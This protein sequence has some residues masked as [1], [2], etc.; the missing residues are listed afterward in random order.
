MEL[1]VN[2]ERELK[3]FGTQLGATLM[4]GEVIELVGDVGAGKTTL[5]K[6]IAAGM[7]VTDDVGSPSY[8]LSQLYEAPHGLR[9]AHYDFYRLDDPGIMTDE[10]SETTSDPR[11]VTAIEWGEMVAGVIPYDH[12][13][14]NITPLSEASRQITLTAGG[15][16]SARFLERL[17]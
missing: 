15:D 13:Q 9:L 14:I 2:S 10:I 16:T 11:I 1:T 6:A 17:K 7:G 5:V 4:G 3:A 12:L 8:T